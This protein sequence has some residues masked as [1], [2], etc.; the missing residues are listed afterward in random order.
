MTRNLRNLQDR[1][2]EMIQ[3]MLGIRGYNPCIIYLAKS[4]SPHQA[5]LDQNRFRRRKNSDPLRQLALANRKVA[6]FPGKRAPLRQ[7]QSAGGGGSPREKKS[8]LHAL[9]DSPL[10]TDERVRD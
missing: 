8:D 10:T 1:R 6:L 9:S 5:R 2:Q 7:F 4:R 3:Q